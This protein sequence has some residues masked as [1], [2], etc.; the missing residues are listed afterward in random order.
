MLLILKASAGEKT[1]RYLAGYV[2]P[3]PIRWG[4]GALL[5]DTHVK[6]GETYLRDFS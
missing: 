6:L 4:Q 5:K 2:T 1:I 3:F